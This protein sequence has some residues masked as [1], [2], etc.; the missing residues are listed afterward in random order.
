MD[1]VSGIDLSEADASCKWSRNAAKDEVQVGGI[2]LRLI[3]LH[4]ALILP[5]QRFL[6]VVLL[7]RDGILLHELLM[8]AQVQLCVFQ[9]GLV[10]HELALRLAEGM[11][12]GR[13]SI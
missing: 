4:G 5:D 11:K 3:C 12:Y 7:A 6:R 13:G 9:Q 1:V 2:D 10:A 8:P